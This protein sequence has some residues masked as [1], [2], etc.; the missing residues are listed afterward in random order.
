MSAGIN[1]ASWI[2]AVRAVVGPEML[3]ATSYDLHGNVS[4][5]IVDAIDIFAAYRT[6]PH[7]DVAETMSAAYAMLLRAL[8]AGERPFV[9]RV[10][11]PLLLYVP[12]WPK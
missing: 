6:A 10:A 12:S 5:K 1:P 8:D 7:I 4:Q 2:A 3:I 9:V 11:V